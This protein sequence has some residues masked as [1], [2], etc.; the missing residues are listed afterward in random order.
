MQKQQEPIVYFVG[1]NRFAMQSLSF[2]NSHFDRYLMNIS[3]ILPNFPDF[4][5][6]VSCIF[7]NEIK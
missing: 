4:W 7:N 5:R 1:T 2:I 6:V 3:T